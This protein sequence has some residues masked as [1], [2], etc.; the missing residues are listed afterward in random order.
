MLHT[1]SILT[2]VPII[3]RRIVHFVHSNWLIGRRWT[4]RIATIESAATFITTISLPKPEKPLNMIVLWCMGGFREA[5]NW[6]PLMPSD[7]SLSDSY[8]SDRNY[9]LF[10]KHP[11]WAGFPSPSGGVAPSAPPLSDFGAPVG[12]P[13]APILETAAFGD[14]KI[15]KKKI[16]AK[17]KQIWAPSAPFLGG[18]C[19]AP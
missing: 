1:R 14:G 5:L 4:S 13:P 12:A 3:G 2:I 8:K 10:A 16:G 19:G 7:A 17:K 11:P 6:C 9:I 18:T 15:T